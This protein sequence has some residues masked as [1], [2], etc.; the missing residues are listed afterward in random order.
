MGIYEI[1]LVLLGGFLAGI[2]NTFAGN[3]SAITLGILT[4]AVGLA[5]NIANGTNRIGVLFQSITGI[6][7]FKQK[8]FFNV[9][10]SNLLI[11]VTILGAF[12][13]V[14]L[15]VNISNEHFKT[16]YKYMMLFIL[17]VI[18][19]K[20]SRWIRP[21]SE[22]TSLPIYIYPLSFLLGVYAGFI[23]MGMGVLF[24]AILVLLAKYDMMSANSIKLVVVALF[25][26]LI[27]PIF[28]FN[29]LVDWK[30]GSLMAAGQILGAATAVNFA[31]KWEN[32]NLWSYRLLV[33]VVILVVL[34][35]FEVFG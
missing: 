7:K 4:E 25:T 14:Y 9:G 12:L 21:T 31:A 19:I 23:Q 18:L 34:R 13:G 10:K 2:V 1:I 33:V 29:G 24:L 17:I 6:L 35:I 5:P 32:A 22:V 27:I 20:P 15:A 28:H 11:T 30:V 8:G 16:V 3:G 26:V